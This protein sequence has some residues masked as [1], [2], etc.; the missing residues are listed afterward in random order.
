M[1]GYIEIL[2]ILK[3]W[4]QSHTKQVVNFTVNQNL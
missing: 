4:T 2:L 1:T 3:Y